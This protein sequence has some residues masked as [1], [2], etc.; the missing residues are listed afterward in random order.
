MREGDFV[1]LDATTKPLTGTGK[2]LGTQDEGRG[3][4]Q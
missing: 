2:R 4:R 3:Q 1:S